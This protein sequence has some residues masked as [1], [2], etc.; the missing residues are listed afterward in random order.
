MAQLRLSN[1]EMQN[2]T[3]QHTHLSIS[4]FLEHDLGN[5]KLSLNVLCQYVFYHTVLTAIVNT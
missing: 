5:L 3:L 1:L 4:L 2:N